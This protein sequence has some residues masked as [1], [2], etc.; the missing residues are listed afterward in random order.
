MSVTP[1]TRSPWFAWTIAIVVYVAAVFHRSTLGVAGL[2]AAHRFGVGPA[3]L[4]TFT[5]LQV[6]VYASMQIP[7]GL[8]VDRFGPRFTLTSAALLLGIGE[9]AFGLAHTYQ[10]M[11]VPTRSSWL[12]RSTVVKP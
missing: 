2:E 3:A 6:A 10:V 1:A 12:F 11:V 9:A 7:T 4:S 8:L 5:V